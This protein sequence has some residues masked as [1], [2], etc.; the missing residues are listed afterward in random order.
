V[1]A[2]VFKYKSKTALLT[3]ILFLSIVQ[4][5]LAALPSAEDI[6][7]LSDTSKQTALTFMRE[8]FN[9]RM[10]YEF[11]GVFLNN[12]DKEQL[13]AR[14][15]QAVDKLAGI[16]EQQH[17]FVQQIEEYQG[18]D[19]DSRYGETGLWRKLKADLYFTILNKSRISLY[20]AF[21]FE[22]P[23]RTEIL[24]ELLKQLDSFY[25]IY[26]KPSLQLIKAQVLAQLSEINE[27]Y[28]TPAKEELAALENRP[29]ISRR[30]AFM[31]ALTRIRFFGANTSDELD[32]LTDA[33]TL[34]TSADDFELILSLTFTR[35]RYD[36]K[37]FERTVYIWPQTEDF[38]GW[39]IMEK[40]THFSN[41]Q[42]LSELNL[43]WLSVFDA[44]LGA[45][46]AWKSNP[47]AQQNIL[48]Q[49]IRIPRFQTPLLYYVTAA[50]SL[51]TSPTETVKFLIKA[52]KLQQRHKSETLDLD[53]QRIAGQAARIGY[54]IY[55]EDTNNCQPG[56]RAFNNYYEICAGN[57][58]E[59]LEYLYAGMFIRCRQNTRGKEMLESIAQRRQNVWHNHAGFD[60]IT[61]AIQ[62][63][64]LPQNKILEQLE[65]LIADCSENQRQL[66]T[67]AIT[68]YCQMQLAEQDP[69]AAQ[70]VVDILT[71]DR[72]GQNRY[73]ILLKSRA[74]QQLNRL[75]EAAEPLLKAVEPNDCQY[76]EDA[77]YFLV[78]ITDRMDQVLEKAND[79]QSF[80]NTCEKIADHCFECSQSQT[81]YY[82]RLIKAEINIFEA[83]EQP[84]KISGI[85][86]FL[87]ELEKDKVTKDVNML[88]CRARLLQE[89]GKFTQ[90][91]E[92][93]AQIC[94]ARKAEAFGQDQRSDQWWRA[95]Y[96]E[97]LCWSKSR[98]AKKQD[99]VHNVEVLENSYSDI[100]LFWAEK[101]NSLKKECI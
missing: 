29:G 71:E 81:Q 83:A 65:A 46:T 48:T 60:L 9:I 43:Q 40:L 80:L 82:A 96:H 77:M 78:K 16:H 28:I 5:L 69:K 87:D 98:N 31:A 58:D 100:P 26:N 10:S 75:D 37:A 68:M 88:R 2:S 38:L 42:Q 41:Q 52:S 6:N 35:G 50:A 12:K 91:A 30:T 20:S 25:L 7:S 18:Q 62:K 85:E 8:T 11:N 97:L 101:L 59:E 4:A 73:L 47:K 45:M 24:R 70:K 92:L 44:E 61:L 89:I 72:I 57:I 63:Q 67:E 56:I 66:R 27:K 54:N 93:W 95:K 22:K 76:F 17:K 23:V 86:R 74:F 14:A 90:S 33:V 36:T 49:L 21:C 99:I 39:L 79:R 1:T 94:E 19:W 51:E 15:R 53:A 34:E 13:C 64:L 3:V 84:E 32:R 55:A